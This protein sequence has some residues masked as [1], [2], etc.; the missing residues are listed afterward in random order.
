MGELFRTDNAAVR[1]ER[2]EA[3]EERGRA[4]TSPSRPALATF[5]GPVAERN[6][7][8]LACRRAM[9]SSFVY[10]G[11]RQGSSPAL[12]RLGRGLRASPSSVEERSESHPPGARSRVQEHRRSC[13][14]RGCPRAWILL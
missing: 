7:L 14:P 9:K 3:S 4:R 8:C 10:V 13:V 6:A 5:H 2:V 12:V 11:I 1:N